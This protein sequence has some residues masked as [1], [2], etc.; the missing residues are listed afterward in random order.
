MQSQIIM[1]QSVIAP[2]VS[3]TKKE[4]QA[5]ADC[6]P[7]SQLK[8]CAAAASMQKR[9]IKGCHKSS[10][11]AQLRKGP[12]ASSRVHHKFAPQGHIHSP[13]IEDNAVNPIFSVIKLFTFLVY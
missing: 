6:S 7:R 2:A 12:A 4:T 9:K 11:C 5:H 1:Y 10:I 3:Q 8:D 13:C